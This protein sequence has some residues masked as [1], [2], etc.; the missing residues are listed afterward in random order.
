MAKK[1]KKKGRPMYR[2]AFLVPLMLALLASCDAL[3]SKPVSPQESTKRFF[4]AF[5]KGVGDVAIRTHG[6]A[7]LLRNEKTRPL[8]AMLD[9]DKDQQLSLA[10]LEAAANL[11]ITEPETA[12]GM[13]AAL[14]V[15]NI[16]PPKPPAPQP[17]KAP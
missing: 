11:F 3:A 4:L 12:A 17:E 1:K 6:T 5:V 2:L 7:A 8:V 14:I 10:E 15:A 13:L 16:P 9:L